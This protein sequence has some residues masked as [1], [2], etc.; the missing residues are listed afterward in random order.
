LDLPLSVV[1]VA[2]VP[3]PQSAH[4]EQPRNIIPQ[5]LFKMSQIQAKPRP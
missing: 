5:W 3:D 4:L 2:D 1:T